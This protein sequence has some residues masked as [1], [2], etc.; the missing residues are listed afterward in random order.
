MRYVVAAVTF[1]AGLGGAV[2]VGAYMMLYGGIMNII[3][4]ATAASVDAGMIAW[5]AIQVFILAELLGGLIFTA[6]FLLAA[7]IGGSDSE[8]ARR[9]PVGGRRMS[10]LR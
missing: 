10:R 5:G 8:F 3:N 1:I 4:G 6:G 9:A 7:A 2:Y